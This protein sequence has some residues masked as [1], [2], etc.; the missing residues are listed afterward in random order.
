M[1]LLK[2]RLEADDWTS[3]TGGL[4]AYQSDSPAPQLQQPHATLHVQIAGGGGRGGGGGGGNAEGGRPL[5]DFISG[6]LNVPS[7][8]LAMNQTER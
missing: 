8:Y 5:L 1:G 7:S 2:E 3:K 6:V 4:I